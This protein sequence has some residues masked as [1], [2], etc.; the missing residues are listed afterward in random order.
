MAHNSDQSSDGRS[1]EREALTGGRIPRRAEADE[2]RS[3]CTR[4]A[5]DASHL[6]AT[7]QAPY[8]N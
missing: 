2:Q 7:R 5:E 8:L 3:A 4:G 6:A 1:D